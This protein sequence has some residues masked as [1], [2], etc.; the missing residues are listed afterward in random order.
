MEEAKKLLI[1]KDF[2]K[3][4][5]LELGIKTLP[6]VVFTEDNNF[7]QSNRSF[8]SYSPNEYS[9]VV[10]T[11]SRNIADVLRSLAHELVHHLQNEEQRIQPGS[12]DDGS[13]IENEANAVAG[14]LLRKYGKINPLIYESKKESLQILKEVIKRRL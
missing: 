14:V 8:G 12:G 11:K 2:I 4:A 7:T 1:V 3:F 9:V 13:D 5:Y 6:S 10:Y